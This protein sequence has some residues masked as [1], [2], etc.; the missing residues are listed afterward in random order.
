M[1]LRN[2]GFVRPWQIL[3]EPLSGYLWLGAQLLGEESARYAEAW[4]LG[5]EE[6]R[7]VTTEE[8]IT[9]AIALYGRGSYVGGTTQTEV[10]TALLRLNWDKAAN[11]LGWRSV[12][13][14]EE[15]VSETIS[16]FK[17]YE[18]RQALAEAVDMY[19]VC[20]G[21]IRAYTARARE[22]GLPWAR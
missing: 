1:R 21:Q 18:G 19:D 8:V 17:M 22:S 2:P 6:R 5:P 15:A 9:K 14:W 12:Y 11:R 7:G 10:E 3:F 20:A 16:W 4:N 13:T